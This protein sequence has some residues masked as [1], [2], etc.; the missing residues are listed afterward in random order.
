[1]N[2][3]KRILTNLESWLIKKKGIDKSM[4]GPKKL[5]PG[6]KC[7]PETDFQVRLNN[8]NRIFVEIEEGQKH[9]EGNVAKYWWWIEK[10]HISRDKN[11]KKVV[12][13]Q[14]F[15]KRFQ[16]GATNKSRVEVCKFLASK[17]KKSYPRIFSYHYLNFKGSKEEGFKKNKSILKDYL[18]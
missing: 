7:S 1:M 3:A 18:G 2:V 4:I 12:L 15:G 9:P 16:N 6:Y 13:I 14:L 17:M 5:I 10:K 8:G 11:I